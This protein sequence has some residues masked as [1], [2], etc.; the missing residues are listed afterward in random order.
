MKNT[1]MRRLL[2]IGASVMLL[3]APYATAQAT[4]ENHDGLKQLLQRY[5]EAD[6]DHNKVLTL[7]EARAYRTRM[8]QEETE[9]GKPIERDAPAEAT[10]TPVGAGEPT[11][12]HVAYGTLPGQVFDLWLPR[13]ATPPCPTVFLL[14]MEQE[15]A[16][17]PELLLKDSLN[18]GISVGVV[19]GRTDG[20]E[21]SYFE[22]IAEALRFV[23]ERGH[24]HGIR[25]DRMGLFGQGVSA[26]HVLYGA[27]IAPAEEENTAGIRCAALLD[28][29]PRVTPEAP[30]TP[31]TCL[32][33]GYPKIHAMLASPHGAPAIAL[34]HTD[35]NTGDAL[36]QALRLRGI[37][38]V[39]SPAAKDEGAA[40]LMRRAALFFNENIRKNV[41]TET[42]PAE[43]KKE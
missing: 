10:A 40:H 36:L 19:H 12:S 4:S 18:V 1:K 13:D 22:D 5:P 39:L 15:S 8:W 17:P 35:P 25:S 42:P 43:T 23:R 33:K 28:P 3:A 41:G 26:E 38:T 21:E 32:E 27:L 29:A 14:T 20:N 34:L 24:S 30:L 16:T 37:D 9:A 31:D 2:M 11:L 6:I 7:E